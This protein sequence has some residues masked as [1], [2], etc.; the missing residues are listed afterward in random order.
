MGCDPASER[1]HCDIVVDADGAIVG[2]WDRL[3]LEQA[4]TNLLANAIKY[5]AGKPIRVGPPP[6]GES[7]A[8][9]PRPRPRHPRAELGRIFQRF[10]RAASIPQLRRP[11][12]GL[13]LIQAIV[14]AHGGSVAAENAADGGARFKVTLPLRAVVA[15]DERRRRRQTSTDGRHTASSSSTTRR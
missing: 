8:R 3:R 7:H 4:L 5:G 12:L 13:Y 9:G 15:R 14:E 6:A 11:G 2:S 1:A 10:E